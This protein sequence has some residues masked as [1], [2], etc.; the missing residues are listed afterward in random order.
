MS[1]IIASIR[2]HPS[3]ASRKGAIKRMLYTSNAIPN[4]A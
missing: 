4:Q 3:Y 2:P 1:G